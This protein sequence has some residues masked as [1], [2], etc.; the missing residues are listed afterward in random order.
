VVINYFQFQMY[1]TP[2]CA[3]VTVVRGL[4]Q[5][6]NSLILITFINNKNKS[7]GIGHI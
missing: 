5:N 2:A 6:Y 4:Q 3:G 7:Q 1:W